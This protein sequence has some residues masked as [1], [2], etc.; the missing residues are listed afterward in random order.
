M[1]DSS[2]HFDDA[3]RQSDFG[4]NDEGSIYNDGREAALNAGKNVIGVKQV[5]QGFD[6]FDMGKAAAESLFEGELT[7]DELFDAVD[8][9][10]SFA[11]GLIE[12]GEFAYAISNAGKDPGGL[13]GALVGN[14]ATFGMNFLMQYVQPVQDLVGILTGNPERIKTSASMWDALSNELAEQATGLTAAAR[15]LDAAWHDDASEAA[16]VR[17]GEGN[18]ILL[19]AAQLSTSVATALEF[20]ASVFEKVQGYL[21][22]RVSDVVGL[23]MEFLISGVPKWPELLL[24]SIPMFIRIILE[25]I[26]VALHVARAFSAL[27]VLIFATETAAQKMTPY[28]DRMSA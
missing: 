12:A 15:K 2:T 20:C 1:G 22:S 28:I 17:I 23:V 11:V 8:S 7:F 10:L 9:A 26:Q 6:F 14:L 21:M 24:E 5:V 27:M 4:V 25:I 18:D 16:V 19:V 3:P 13:I